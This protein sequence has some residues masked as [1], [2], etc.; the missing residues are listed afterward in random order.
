MS[1]IPSRLIRIVS[2]Y[3]TLCLLMALSSAIAQGPQSAPP[4]NQ[5]PDDSSPNSPSDPNYSNNQG[6]ERNQPAAPRND[7]ANYEVPPRLT[8]KA[9]TFV[10]VRINQWLSS[11]RSQPG[12]AFS[13][14]LA[15]PIVVDGV[16]V[17]E[18]GQTL[19][20]RVVESRKAGRVEGVS[21]L[22]IQLTELS[23]VDGQQLPIQTQWITRTGPTSLGRDAAAIG[24]TSA[25]GAAVGAAANG[26]VGAG[27]G[28]AAGAVVGTVGVLLTRGRPTVIYPES[29]LTFRIETPVA[30]STERA[31]Q[32]F[33]YVDTYDYGRESEAQ[34]P[35]PARACPEGG[36]PPPPPPYYYYGGW[37]YY[38]PYYYGPTFAFGFGPRFFYGGR[39][40][41]GRGF[42][43][44]GFYG[45]GF[46]GR[47]R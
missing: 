22:G 39:G 6:P 43:G 38:Y 40:F 1:R 25:V 47:R 9:G 11:D 33:H 20:G 13:A 2:N 17:A 12:D 19:G 16:V 10:T 34:G 7:Q 8:I 24:G 14:T 4:P 3:L 32:A 28:A 36:C 42:Y 21:R 15:R 35:P 30:V 37:P 31:S 44:R 29:L 18:R 26:G 27:I 41:Y 23:L 46:G 45:R 5:P